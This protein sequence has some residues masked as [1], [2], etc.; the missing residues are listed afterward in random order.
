MARFKL[1]RHMTLILSLAATLVAGP[2]FVPPAH[3][4]QSKDG[5][6]DPD[7]TAPPG[8][9]GDPDMPVG[10]NKSVGSGAQRNA[11]VGRGARTEG[12]GRAPQ[13]VMVTRLRIVMQALRVIYFRF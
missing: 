2:A 13:S 8:A 4:L 5:T 6:A 1:N 7:P 10:P 9:S 11:V 3:C 12:D